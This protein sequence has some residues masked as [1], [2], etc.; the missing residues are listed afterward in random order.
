M[1]ALAK[2]VGGTIEAELAAHPGLRAERAIA[3]A[4]TPATLA[5]ID[6]GLD[7]L[8]AERVEGHRLSLR[9]VQQSCS[10]LAS[11]SLAERCR[12]R[13]VDPERAPTIV[14][15]VVI[16]IKAMRAFGLEQVEVSDR[17]ILYGAALDVAERA[18]PLQ[19]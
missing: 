8:D 12:I 5:A 10:Q 16:L 3:V 14:A 7:H 2:D 15:G 18:A 9:M 1:E 6:L 19:R 4:G 17:D 11:A 13:G